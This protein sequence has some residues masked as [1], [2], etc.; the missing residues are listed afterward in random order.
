VNTLLAS[1]AGSFS[2]FVQVLSDYADGKPIPAIVSVYYGNC[3][4]KVRTL[5]LNGSCLVTHTEPT[6]WAKDAPNTDVWNVQA[7]LL[8]VTF[9]FLFLWTMQ[10]DQR[11]LL[12]FD[13]SYF[14][15][16]TGT[17]LIPMDMGERLSTCPRV[18]DSEV[19]LLQHRHRRVS[20]HWDQ[21]DSD[22]EQQ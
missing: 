12:D 6:D 16:A 14:T 8:N 1:D 18:R 5:G 13:V 19:L 4:G 20:H 22:I 11:R 15:P 17:S 9:P 10:E 3:T 2:S 21:P 7:T